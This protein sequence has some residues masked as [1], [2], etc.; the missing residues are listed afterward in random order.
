MTE[1]SRT[2]N[3]DDFDEQIREALEENELLMENLVPFKK[4]VRRPGEIGSVVTRLTFN[5]DL[6]DG[7]A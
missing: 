6:P 4:P 2:F 5:P 7:A 1:F 3:F